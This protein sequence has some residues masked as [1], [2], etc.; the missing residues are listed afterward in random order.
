MRWPAVGR[1]SDLLD[2]RGPLTA[3]ET[4][5]VLRPL[6]AA[7]AAIHRHGLVHGN[8]SAAVVWFDDS[9]RPL[10]GG[11]AAGLLAAHAVPGRDAAPQ[12]AADLAPECARGAAPSVAADMFS[13]GSV[14]L[15]CLTGRS[16]WPADDTA[17][18]LVQ[19][20]GGVW[21]DV[22]DEAAPPRLVSLIRRMLAADPAARPEATAVLA[23]L[24]RSGVALPVDLAVDLEADFG[25]DVGSWA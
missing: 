10:F 11:L 16:A 1:L 14:A 15:F 3:G 9:G 6:A 7:L 23:E 4:L 19:S 24:Q 18:V 22:P 21:P 20:V 13:L 25:P 17:D 12:R 2:R 5:T 8:L